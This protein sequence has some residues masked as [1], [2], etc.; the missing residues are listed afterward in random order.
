MKGDW[1]WSSSSEDHEGVGKM[2]CECAFLE[3]ESTA[4]SDSQQDLGH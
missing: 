3:V 2:L 4:S 1:V